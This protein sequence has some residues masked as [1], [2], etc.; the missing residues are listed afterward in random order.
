MRL[1]GRQLIDAFKR[2]HPH[3]RRVMDRWC[4]FVGSTVWRTPHDVKRDFRHASILSS[5]RVV[6][7]VGGNRYRVVAEVNYRW[8][9]V[10]IRFVGTHAAYD[11]IDALTC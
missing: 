11:R 2:T 9:V 8:R 4:D 6:F 10:Q 1:I 7:N 5:N 3:A